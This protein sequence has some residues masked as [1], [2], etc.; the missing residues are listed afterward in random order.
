MDADPSEMA[1]AS[2]ANADNRYSSVAMMLHWLIAVAV[3]AMCATGVWMVDAIDVKETRADAFAVYQWHK[4]LG[5]TILVLMVLRIIWRLTHRPP[6]LPAGMK[7]L[8]RLA[9]HTTHLGFYLLLLVIPLLGWAMVSA[10]VYGLPTIWFGLF[11]W[12]H[13][14]LLSGLENKKPVEDFLRS[15]HGWSAYLLIGLIVV[16]LAAVAKHTFVD[17]D[18]IL[19][20]MLPGGKKTKAD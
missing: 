19:K 4:S 11:E 15:A 10:S 2:S 13:L 20:R 1:R 17:R 16:H 18:G 3:L 6:D 12:P 5:L 9:A 7:T 14:P 8:E